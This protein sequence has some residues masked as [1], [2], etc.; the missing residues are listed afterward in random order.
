MRFGDEVRLDLRAMR[1]R[2]SGSAMK[3]GARFGARWRR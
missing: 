2:R 3:F 1:C